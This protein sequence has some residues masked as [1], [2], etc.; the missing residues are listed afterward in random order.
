MSAK[1][2]NDGGKGG[3]RTKRRQKQQDPADWGDISAD[4]IKGFVL[5]AQRLDGAVRFGAS[6]DGGVFS[7]GFYVGD[8]RFTEWVRNDDERDTEFARIWDEIADDFSVTETIL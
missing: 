1:E 8:E 3:K 5:L 4:T 7:I 6:R 2:R